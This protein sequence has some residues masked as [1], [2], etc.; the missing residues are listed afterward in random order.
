MEDASNSK[1]KS[2]TG[3]AAAVAASDTKTKFIKR[4]SEKA[5]TNAE[6][7]NDCAADED[8]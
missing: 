7:N 8:L 4:A 5:G 6:N 1:D 3:A 2:A